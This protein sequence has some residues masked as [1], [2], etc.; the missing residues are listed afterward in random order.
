MTWLLCVPTDSASTDHAT[1]LRW[2]VLQGVFLLNNVL[3]VQKSK[4]ASHKKQGWEQFTTAVVRE[5]NKLDNVVFM[6]WG[7]PAQVRHIWWPSLC[8]CPLDD[9]LCNPLFVCCLPPCRRRARCL[10]DHAT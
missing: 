5:L 10:I 8:H 2:M 6:L 7:K 3:T 4:A 9:S 1:M